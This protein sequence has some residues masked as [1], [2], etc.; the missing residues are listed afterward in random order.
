[1]KILRRIILWFIIFI[2]LAY[3]GSSIFFI[4]RGKSLLEERLSA[5]CQRPVTLSGAR[6]TF[7]L[8]L[9]VEDLLIPQI[10]Q[11]KSVDAHFSIWQIFS[12]PFKLGALQFY[13]ATFFVV[14][15]KDRRLLWEGL[16]FLPVIPQ[17][18][19]EGK[20]L[21]LGS[22]PSQVKRRGIIIGNL[23]VENGRL[24][25]REFAG[26]KELRGELQ[27]VQLRA[28][29]VS[30]PLL[31]RKIRFKGTGLIL[32]KEMPF[33]G[34]NLEVDGWVDFKKLDMDSY[35]KLFESN[36]KVGATVHV[37][38]AKNDMTVSGKM[39]LGMLGST[40]KTKNVSE[41]S[42]QDFALGALQNSGLDIDLN[43]SFR[44]QMNNF[45]IDK[46]SLNGEVNVKDE[47]PAAASG[48]PAKG[49]GVKA[50]EKSP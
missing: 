37:H 29:N 50:I 46:I 23:E 8:G 5:F 43:F 10:V 20:K 6:L 28:H 3:L 33:S 9:R 12:K 24:H 32:C 1:M 2:V 4:V 38:S 17:P 7:P 35:L 21:D 16:Y 27:K 15:T 49:L 11:A 45:Q 39:N 26:E 25:Y 44:T 30:Y 14:H 19:R 40:M 36:G 31:A 42:F 47:K 13:D 34:Q 41:F 48:S 18:P 22:K